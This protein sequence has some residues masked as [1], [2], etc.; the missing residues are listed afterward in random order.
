[1][2]SNIKDN[3]IKRVLPVVLALMCAATLIPSDLMLAEAEAATNSYYT[4]RSGSWGEYA[5]SFERVTSS[6]ETYGESQESFLYVGTGDEKEYIYCTDFSTLFSTGYKARYDLSDYMPDSVIS[7]IALGHKYIDSYADSNSLSTGN[8]YLLKQLY[9][10][11]IQYENGLASDS[12]VAIL[13][14]VGMDNSTQASVF[15]AAKSYAQEN[16]SAYTCGGYAY[17]DEENGSQSAADFWYKEATGKL[18]LKKVSADTDITDGNS[19]YSLT[20]VEYGVYSDSGCTKSVGTLNVTSDGTS[21]TIELDAGTYYVKETKTT[22]GYALD[23]TVHK[24]TV[25]AGGTV[26]VSVSDTPKSNPVSLIVAKLDSETGENE[27]QGGASLSGAQFTVKYYD[28]YYDTDP[29]ASGVSATRTWVISTDENGEATLSDSVKVSGDS[30]YYNSAGDAVLP[31]GTVTI[32][33]TKAPE[34]YLADDTVYVRQVTSDGDIETVDTYNSPTVSEDVIRGGIMIQKRDLQSGDAVPEGAATLSGAVFAIT[35]ENDHAVLVDGVSYDPGEV[36]M[37]I[38]T[39]ED[40]IAQTAAD[41]LPYGEYSISETSGPEGYLNEGVIYQEF[42]IEEDGVIVDLTGEADSILNQVKRGDFEIT[43]INSDTQAVMGGVTFMI[44]S[45]TTGETHYFTTDANG[46]YSSASGWNKHSSNTNGGGADD[47][48]WFGLDADGNNVEVDDDLGALPYD[49]YTITEIEGDVNE[50]MEMLVL[51]LTISRDSVTIDMGN[52]END[53]TGTLQTEAVDEE[54]GLHYA[55]ADEETVIV[56][57]VSYENLKKGTYTLVTTLMDA[58]T[59]TAICNADGTAV[60]SETEFS[61]SGSG[62]VKTEL[63]FASADHAGKSVVVYEMLYLDGELV[64]SHCDISDTDQTVYIPSLDTTA[65][66]SETGLHISNA[67][68]SATVTDTVSYTNLQPKR[69]FTM[70]GTLYDAETGEALTDAIGNEVTV[71]KTFYS[72]SDGEGSVTMEFII[73]ASELA[74]K[75]VVVCES[76][77]RNDQNAY[78]YAVHKDLTDEDQMVHFPKIG[79]T[80]TAED[81]EDHLTM[82]DEDITIT[83]TV[84]YENLV[85]GYEYT[86]TG[87]LMDAATGKA[88][89]DDAGEEV[90]ATAVFTP[91]EADG[92]VKMNFTFSGEALG[93]TTTVVFESLYVNSVLVAEHRDLTD[94]DQTVYI[95]EIGTEASDAETGTNVSYADEDITIVDTVSYTNLL[96]GRTYTMCGTLYDQESGEAFLDDDGNEITAS[97]EFTPSDP[98][99]TV[100]VAFTFSGVSMAGTTAVA[101]ETLEYEGKT[102]AVHADLTDESQTVYI[103]EIGTTAVDSETNGHIACGDESVTIV[104]KVSFNNLAPG[105]EYTVTGTLMDA[106]TGKAVTDSNGDA[107]T[108]ETTFTPVAASG[109]VEVT[110]TFDASALCGHTLVVSETLTVNGEVAAKHEDLND[111]GQTVYIPE[112]HTNATDTASG[113]NVSNHDSIITIEDVVTYENLIPGKEYVLTGTLMDKSTGKALKD[114]NGDKVTESVAFTPDTADGEVTVTFTFDG[115]TLGGTTAV[116]FETLTYE[117]VEVAV[118]T[119]IDDEDQTVYIPEIGTKAVDSE[120]KKHTSTADSSVTIVDTVSYSDL[121][122]GKEYK[123]TGILMDKETGKAFTDADGKTVTS[124]ATFTAEESSGTVEVE[125]TF[126]GTGLGG[127]SVVVYEYLYLDSYLVTSHEDIG[128]KAQTVKLTAPKTTSHPKT[129]DGAKAGMFAALAAAGLAVAVLAAKRR[130]QAK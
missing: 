106:D 78:T 82:A 102:Y 128:D 89:V 76:V 51:T 3:L 67:D 46:Y 84:A 108:A 4:T 37:S 90:T 115:V 107:V 75:T 127:T 57:T 59:G 42:S 104:D 23:K 64:A 69:F 12:D 65:M 61:A 28:G 92:E 110:F 93:G 29:A 100:E 119:D 2:S 91:E 109:S 56:D 34:G 130:R 52:V 114:D 38:T 77:I 20:D 32:E 97:A 80:A 73:D 103:P 40:G 60:Q 48:L 35:N 21:N 53:E 26:T 129:S 124:E 13:Y 31:L 17:I 55:I 70:V 123:V 9:T 86:L 36:V 79:T 116:A 101:F 15:S 88:I 44:T 39:D 125:F 14:I 49:T 120:T 27:P 18:S 54:T 25:T 62:Q 63:V 41:V 81:S 43:K 45:N 94:E 30:F 71:R 111:E 68:D 1:M 74:G 105:H 66:D 83:D 117:G 19:C 98:D 33:E 113:T 112:I 96:P 24:V 118:H 10:W 95:P 85:P 58:D 5:G 126:N 11:R 8:R 121:A 16:A 47:G 22:D 99:G 87:T 7:L 72:G 122:P 6:G 50:G